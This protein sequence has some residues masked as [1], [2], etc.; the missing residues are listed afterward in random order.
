MRKR[1]VT[2]ELDAL[3][4][5]VGVQVSIQTE[6]HPGDSASLKAQFPSAHISWPLA[7][8]EKEDAHLAVNE[9][10]CP[11]PNPQALAANTLLFAVKAF[12]KRNSLK[13]AA[14]PFCTESPLQLANY[15]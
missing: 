2:M 7:N 3:H 4:M 13:T 5:Y 15:M 10:R 6:C 11:N 8:T 9:L 1:T 12:L 14:T